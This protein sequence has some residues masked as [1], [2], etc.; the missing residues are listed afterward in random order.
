MDSAITTPANATPGRSRLSLRL[1]LAGGWV[2]IGLLNMAPSPV[3]APRAVV[4]AALYADPASA[5]PASAAVGEAATVKDPVDS[6]AAALTDCP[7]RLPNAQ[8]MRIAETINQESAEHGYD[9]LFITALI[10]I[11]SGCRTGVN[12]RGA[13]GLTQL[14]PSTARAVAKRAG[15]RWNGSA[16]LKDPHENVRIGVQYLSELQGMLDCPFRAMAAYNMGP[17]P[18]LRM[19]SARAKRVGYVRKIMRRYEQLR[20]DHP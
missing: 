6:I 20:A 3:E 9:P 2:L 12:G 16:T 1:G 7:N 19:S 11:E 18:V 13:I 8:R 5:D 10:Q 15:V 4:A 14:L 17:R